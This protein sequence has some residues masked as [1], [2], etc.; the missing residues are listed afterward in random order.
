MYI[1]QMGWIYLIT[2][3]KNNKCYVG[4]TVSKR[5]EKRW[6]GHRRRPQG[7]LKLAFNKYGLESFK[8][9]TICELDDKEQ[10]DEREILEIKNRDTVAP[11][12]Y[13]L[14][15]GGTRNKKD[16]NPETRLK[17]SVSHIGH[18]HTELAKQKIGQS[19][20][21]RTFSE[22]HRQAISKARI[23]MKFTDETR[24]KISIAQTARTDRK[25]GVEHHSS[26]KVNQYSKDGVFIKTHDSLS[27][28]ASELGVKNPS[29]ISQ[30]CLGK[31]KTSRGFIW[32]YY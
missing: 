29:G 22:E 23:G 24:K 14:E 12:G 19:S 16:V 13:N 1:L 18:K 6:S 8:F 28:A 17:M 11:N 3:T 9:E 20:K 4:Q 10:L 15:K 25:Y 7:L 30:C 21:G 26:K 5:V 31:L 32:T 2:N 27:L